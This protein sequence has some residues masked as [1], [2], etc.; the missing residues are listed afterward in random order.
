M[1]PALQSNKRWAKRST[2]PS[3]LP[4]A[5]VGVG[6][7]W[8]VRQQVSSEILLDQTTTVTLTAARGQSAFARG[9]RIADP[10]EPGLEPG[11]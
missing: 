3:A 7:R 2:G 5:P 11:R 1:L 8:V 4:D 9:G 6:A 10:A